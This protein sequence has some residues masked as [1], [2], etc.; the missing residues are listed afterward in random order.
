MSRRRLTVADLTA[1]PTWPPP[2]GGPPRR[3]LPLPSFTSFRYAEFRYYWVS[4]VL[5]FFDH[6]M[7]NVALAWLV[8]EM[9]DSAGW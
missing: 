9:T 7:A 1:E 5:V 4:A 6:G 8:L 2:K 3:R